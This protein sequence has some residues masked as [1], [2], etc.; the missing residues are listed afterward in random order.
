[1]GLGI[2]YTRHKRQQQ[3]H[4]SRKTRWTTLFPPFIAGFIAHCEHSSTTDFDS[5][6]DSVMGGSKRPAFPATAA[7]FIVILVTMAMAVG[8]GA[9]A[10][11]DSS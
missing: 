8:L 3:A 9:L 5:L 6:K 4:V 7:A 10:Q 2:W 11:P 1:M